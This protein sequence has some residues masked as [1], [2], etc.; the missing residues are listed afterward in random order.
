[1]VTPIC[2]YPRNYNA[3]TCIGY[4]QEPL[5]IALDSTDRFM[6]HQLQS[7]SIVISGNAMQ[8]ILSVDVDYIVL[9]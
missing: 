6:G 7:I 5:I 4:L 8:C 3:V 9:C 1:M 2:M